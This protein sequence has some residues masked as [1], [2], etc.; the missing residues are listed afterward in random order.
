MSLECSFFVVPQSELS[1]P[2]TSITYLL[3]KDQTLKQVIEQ[4]RRLPY[5]ANNTSHTNR[6]H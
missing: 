1:S 3:P 6:Q 5:V 4:L 2:L